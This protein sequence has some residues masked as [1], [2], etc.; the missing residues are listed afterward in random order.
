MAYS[1]FSLTEIQEKFQVELHQH[2]SLFASIEPIPLSEALTATLNENVSLALAIYTEKARSELIIAPILVELRKMFDRKISFF[3]GREFNVDAE[4]GLVG[5]CD[6]IISQSA[7]LL[8][9][10]APVVAM[11]EAK[12][13]DI[14]GSLPQC[15]AEMLAAQVFNQQ[16]KNHIQT[17][18]GV[19]T[20]GNLWKFLTL[21]DRTV[22]VDLDEYHISQAGKLMAILH[23][24]VQ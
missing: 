6:F 16:A 2:A 24:M 14:R 21:E 23:H 7:E 12:N 18:Y 4:Q 20:T 15:I 10:T 5:V 1:Q 19:V 11:V 17:V 9:I 13:E 8:L 3:S 22:F